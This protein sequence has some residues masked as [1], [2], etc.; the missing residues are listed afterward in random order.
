MGQAA[1]KEQRYGGSHQDGH[2]A[3]GEGSSSSS[4]NAT[5]ARSYPSSVDGGALEPQGVYTGPQDYSHDVVK[6]AI[7][8]RKLM[9]FYKGKDDEDAYD[10]ERF[11]SE[12]PIC[13]LYYPSTLNSTRC[14]AQPICTECFVQI[15]RADPGH[16]NP[17]SSQPAECPF[18]TAEPF[19]ILY[20][21]PPASTQSGDEQA[22]QDGEGSPATAT[23]STYAHKRRK[24]LPHTDPDVLTTD[25]IRPDWQQKL[26]SA[27]AATLRRA[28]RRIIMRQVGDRL[29]PIG[30][31]SSRAGADL[32]EGN[33]PGGAII[34]Q[35]GERWGPF[36]A[37]DEG[38]GTGRRSS[39]RRGAAL[40]MGGQDVEEMML[41]EAMRLSLIE[42]EEQQRRQ[43]EANR[44]SGA[45]QP[46]TQQAAS[47]ASPAAQPAG[48][49]PSSPPANTNT[50]RQST[51]GSP[52]TPSKGLGRSS[53]TSRGQPMTNP[54]RR[55]ERLS[56][57]LRSATLADEAGFSSSPAAGS[58]VPSGSASTSAPIRATNA[59]PSFPASPPKAAPATSSSATATAPT[60]AGPSSPSS[61]AAARPQ[62]H[63]FGLRDD[64]LAEL[65]ELI[66]EPDEETRQRIATARRMKEEREQAEMER[67]RKAQQQAA[68]VN[69][70][71]AASGS[72]SPPPSSPTMGSAR[73]LNPNNP[74]RNRMASAESSPTHSRTS[75]AAFA[76]FAPSQ[77]GGA[78]QGQ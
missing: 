30:I 69:A 73:P 9:P 52:S 45:A 26:A 3:N 44:R 20:T 40:Q 2:H 74:F 42:H 31:S 65:S 72:A 39:S 58:S 76:S 8:Q 25:M 16:T 48:G 62:S 60:A 22:V 71:T 21:P 47:T 67:V 50:T 12:C 43:A 1:T 36:S 24:S 70:A 64:M 27:Q 55:A 13:F 28:N 53:S 49:A 17:P 23:P 29:I 33:G 77:S 10:G 75:S 59:A 7:V 5:P 15:K 78:G 35:Q 4:A 46:E 19:G 61:G 14:C 32:P 68:S 56:Q 6:T 18:C 41:M 11:N 37:T 54:S 34:L 66:D 38:Q 57:D 51:D 63:N